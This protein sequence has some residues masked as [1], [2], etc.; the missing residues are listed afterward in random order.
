MYLGH[1]Q[2]HRLYRVPTCNYQTTIGQL[3]SSQEILD[4][5]VFIAK[6]L[7]VASEEAETRALLR[8]EDNDRG[9]TMAEE[10]ESQ[11][12]ETKEAEMKIDD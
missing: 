6:I 4:D 5:M 8:K 11:E 10:G 9:E 12:A 3:N 7:Q 1:D 2:Q